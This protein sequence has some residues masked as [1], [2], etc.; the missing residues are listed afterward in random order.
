MVREIWYNLSY[1]Q[2]LFRPNQCMNDH[3]VTIPVSSIIKLYWTAMFSCL[4]IGYNIIWY[5]LS[6][7]MMSLFPSA[8]CHCHWFLNT[9]CELH[10]SILTLCSPNLGLLCSFM[11]L[12]CDPTPA[13]SQLL[14]YSVAVLYGTNVGHYTVFCLRS[15]WIPSLCLELDF[16]S[17]AKTPKPLMFNFLA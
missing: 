11:F 4:R 8:V 16:R 6:L 17:T 7:V 10:V 2:Y 15:S 12:C 1:G 14:T 9:G 5:S 3:K 13:F